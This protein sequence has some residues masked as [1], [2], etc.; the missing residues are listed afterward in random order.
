MGRILVMLRIAV[1][2]SVCMCGHVHGYTIPSGENIG[3]CRCHVENSC[4]SVCVCVCVC[5]GM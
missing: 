4:V 2:L 3:V 1:C 5:M